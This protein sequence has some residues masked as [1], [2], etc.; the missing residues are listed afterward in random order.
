MG[1]EGEEKNTHRA[2]NRSRPNKGKDTFGCF[3]K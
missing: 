2:E 3:E 1:N